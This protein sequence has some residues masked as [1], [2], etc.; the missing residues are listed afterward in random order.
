MVFIYMWRY[1]WIGAAFWSFCFRE[2]TLEE[3]P[4]SRPDKGVTSWRKAWSDGGDNN[5]L[6]TELMS[7]ILG[8]RK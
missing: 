3:E 7:Q 5:I 8:L 2:G 1:L 4:M 6:R